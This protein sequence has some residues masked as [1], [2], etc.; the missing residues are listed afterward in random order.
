ME[1]VG[2]QHISS[3]QSLLTETADSDQKKSSGMLTRPNFIA[4]DQRC[5]RSLSRIQKIQIIHM[6]I[7]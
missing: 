1:T 5:T 3:Y 4:N 6:I 7:Y 2:M